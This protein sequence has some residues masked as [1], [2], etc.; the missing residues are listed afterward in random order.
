M[1]RAGG[2]PAC[3]VS[4]LRSKATWFIAMHYKIHTPTRKALKFFNE[5]VSTMDFRHV[6]KVLSCTATIVLLDRNFLELMVG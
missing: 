3:M 4:P 1:V 2:E 5:I 6:T